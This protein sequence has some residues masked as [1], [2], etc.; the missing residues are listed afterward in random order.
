VQRAFHSASYAQYD[1][2]VH[3]DALWPWPDCPLLTVPTPL[4][5]DPTPQ[6]AAQVNTW[7]RN[8]LRFFTGKQQ[9]YCMAR[10]AALKGPHDQQMCGLS[11]QGDYAGCC[12]RNSSIQWPVQ[13]YL[14]NR[15][16]EF[17][18]ITWPT[19]FYMIQWLMFSTS[20]A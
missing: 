19:Y 3:R 12:D 14:L 10:G 6:M 13:F 20:C 11:N 9:P 15:S 8:W 7:T 17:C 4:G 5:P 18:L 2:L 1:C 16:I